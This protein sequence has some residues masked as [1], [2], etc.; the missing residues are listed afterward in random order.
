VFIVIP[1]TAHTL[2]RVRV[3][4]TS[5]RVDRRVRPPSFYACTCGQDLPGESRRQARPAHQAHRR[6]VKA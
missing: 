5:P 3:V 6:E 1:N 4:G 2:T